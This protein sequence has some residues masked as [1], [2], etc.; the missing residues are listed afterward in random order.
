MLRGADRSRRELMEGAGPDG[1]D[2]QS[3]VGL[4]VVWKR[5]VCS[6]AG[7]GAEGGIAGCAKKEWRAAGPPVARR[8]FLEAFPNRE[9]WIHHLCLLTLTRS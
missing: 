8:E 9:A 4:E 2:V 7:Q 6:S 1:G 3:G 5:V